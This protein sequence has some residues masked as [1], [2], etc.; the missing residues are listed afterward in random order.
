MFWIKNSR[1]L[2]EY[3][4]INTE[5]Q[6]IFFNKNSRRL[7]TKN[8]KGQKRNGHQEYLDGRSIHEKN[9]YLF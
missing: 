8:G 9:T 3:S 7:A 6:K 1:N 4:R 5:F 2:R